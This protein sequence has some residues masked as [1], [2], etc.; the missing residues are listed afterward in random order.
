MNDKFI[1]GKWYKLREDYPTSLEDGRYITFEGRKT[2]WNVE[3]QPFLD[4]KP[5]KVVHIGYIGSDSWIVT[6][7]G[8][9]NGGWWYHP[10]DFDQ[11]K[12][13]EKTGGK[14]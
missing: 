2:W 14:R 11:V 7:E 13:I 8:I 9:K 5:R 10:E 4:K 6:F 12:N 1:V 3:K